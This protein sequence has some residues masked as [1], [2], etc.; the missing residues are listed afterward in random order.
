[1]VLA[2]QDSLLLSGHALLNLLVDKIATLDSER[3][4]SNE[5]KNERDRS[6]ADYTK[7]LSDLNSLINSIRSFDKRMQA[8]AEVVRTTITFADGVRA[9]WTTSHER[10]CEKAF[11]LGIFGSAVSICQM[12]GAGGTMAITAGA[13]LVGVNMALSQ[14]KERSGKERQSKKRTR[15]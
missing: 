10:I 13:A 5:K 12:A 1:M 6:L 8:E 11:D 7:L 3:P 4:N 15:K 14:T 9:W 2:N